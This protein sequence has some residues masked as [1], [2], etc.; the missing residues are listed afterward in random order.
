MAEKNNPQKASMLPSDSN[1]PPWLKY[2]PSAVLPYILLARLERPI[3]TYLLFWP[4]IWGLGLAYQGQN[5]FFTGFYSLAFFIGALLMRGAGCTLNDL[6]DRKIDARVARTAHRPLASGHL[7]P[8]AA[9]LFFALQAGLAFLILLLFNWQTVLV[10]CLSLPI[11]ALYPFA[12]RITYWPQLVLGLAF[13]WGV[14]VG[15]LALNPHFSFGTLALYLAGI[16]WTIGYDTLY[17]HQDREEDALIGVRSTALLF[18]K[19]TR[20]ILVLFYSIAWLLFCFALLLEGRNYW[21][22]FF[23]LPVL[24]HFIWQIRMLDIN[25]PALCLTLFKSNTWVGFFVAVAILLSAL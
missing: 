15:Y 8:K 9:L 7:K 13:N 1:A 12:K 18:G 25:N 14:W 20:K 21:S 5:L 6:A 23:F 10:A 19:N 17:A 11:V 2:L 3:G 24:A 16:F 22:L 4:C